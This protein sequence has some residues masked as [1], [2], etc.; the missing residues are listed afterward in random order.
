MKI[1]VVGATGM[2]GNEVTRQLLAH[3]SISK[4]VAFVR[5][6]LPA[7]MSSQSKLELVKIKD[8]AAWP[9]HVLQ[10]HA[11]AAAMVW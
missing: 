5:R 4:V 1:L 9:E 11:D 7:D 8:F 6:D 10:M 2:I 3:P